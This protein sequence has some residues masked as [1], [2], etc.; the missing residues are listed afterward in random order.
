M[1]SSTIKIRNYDEFLSWDRP[2]PGKR[3]QANDGDEVPETSFPNRSA[4][5]S[6]F[7]RIGKPRSGERTGNADV[8]S[9]KLT[10]TVK[11]TSKRFHN[12]VICLAP[13]NSVIQ[14]HTRCTNS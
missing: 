4:P 12:L 6:K 2:V 9:N 10:G 1:R 11:L 7:K 5:K 14:A 3:E 13:T 8:N